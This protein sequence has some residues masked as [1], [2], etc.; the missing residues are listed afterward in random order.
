MHLRRRVWTDPN[1]SSWL[2]R[3]SQAMRPLASFMRTSRW[4]DSWFAPSI[5]ALQI[6]HCHGP[7]IS[8]NQHPSHIHACHRFSNKAGIPVVSRKPRRHFEDCKRCKQVPDCRMAGR[9]EE[10]AALSGPTA[11]PCGLRPG[12]AAVGTCIR[13]PPALRASPP[14]GPHDNVKNLTVHLISI[15]PS[16]ACLDNNPV[17]RRGKPESQHL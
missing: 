6:F 7:M 3:F 10:D 17:E 8:L 13:A 15:L 1:P 5:N 4:W 16:P 12:P 14:P 9:G 11:I 2:T